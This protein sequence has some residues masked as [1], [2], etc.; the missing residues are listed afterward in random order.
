MADANHTPAAAV[1]RDSE[2]FILRLP[3]GMRDRLKAIAAANRRTMNAEIIERLEDSLR[4]EEQR[5]RHEFEGWYASSGLMETRSELEL[6]PT[7]AGEYQCSHAQA[8]WQA[9]RA[10][11]L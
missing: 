10:A 2:K 11:R 7:L 5:L 8:A 9:W 1:G 6:D 3:A 4:A